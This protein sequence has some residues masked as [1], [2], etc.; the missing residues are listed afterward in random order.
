M[1]HVVRK[2]AGVRLRRIVFI[3]AAV[4]LA[5]IVIVSMSVTSLKNEA[6]AS[7]GAVDPSLKQPLRQ[8]VSVVQPMEAVSPSA[9]PKARP[10]TKPAYGK[11][12]GGIAKVASPAVATK[13]YAFPLPPAPKFD[14]DASHRAT[15]PAIPDGTPAQDAMQR[16]FQ[17]NRGLLATA[18]GRPTSVTLVS[19]IWN[20]GRGSMPTSDLWAVLRRP[21][22]YYTAGL[23]T[24]L[25]YNLPKVL[26]TDADT[27]QVI[28]PMVDDAAGEVKVIIRSMEEVRADFGAAN[29]DAVDR[30]RTSSKWLGQGAMV[31]NS[32]QALLK[33]FNPLVM[34]KLRFTR[35]AARWNP[36]GTDGFLWMDGKGS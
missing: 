17:A 11:D 6:G 30:I 36:F 16:V 2:S 15:T 34:S 5:T 31:A 23:E 22:T 1:R 12:G 28:K 18:Q 20:I 24:F 4:S 29:A 33:D 10:Q 21:F 8:T 25:S 9:P 35:D 27:Y 19:G 13:A 7:L 14:G 26:Y 3:T 32:P